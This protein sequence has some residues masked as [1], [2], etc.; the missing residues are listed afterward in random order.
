[1]SHMA[2]WGAARLT[3]IGD[4]MMTTMRTPAV[5]IV[6]CHGARAGAHVGPLGATPMSTLGVRNPCTV[7]AARTALQVMSRPTTTTEGSCTA[8]S[9]SLV[10]HRL[11]L[12]SLALR[13]TP[14]P[15]VRTTRLSPGA[16]TRRV[17]A[18]GSLVAVGAA[19]EVVAGTTRILSVQV[20]LHKKSDPKGHHRTKCL[21]LTLKSHT[22]RPS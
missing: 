14:A 8:A 16:Q 5:R 9:H 19:G 3:V 17:G 13:T 20:W 12:P 21:A 22:V 11:G 10:A 18:D 15:G 7:T 2:T 6:T 1:M 4:G